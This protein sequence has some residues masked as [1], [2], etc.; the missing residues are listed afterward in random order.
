MYREAL[1]KL[2]ARRDLEPEE[3]EAVIAEL[4]DGA[5]TPEEMSALLVA[6]TAKGETAAELAGFA[7]AMRAR[8]VKVDAG[9]GLLDTCGTGGSGLTTHNTS[10]M[11]AFVTAAAGGRIAKHGNRASTGKCGSMDVL[12][13]LDVPID[14]GPDAVATLIR[15]LGVGFMLAPRHH[16]AM[17]HVAPVRKALGVR[18]TFNFV[19]PLSNPAGA[20][21]QLLG[22]SDR[23]RARPMA[24]AL[25]AL[26]TV[27]AMIVNGDDGL[28]EITL[29]GSTLVQRVEGGRVTEERIEP[30]A[31][32]LRPVPFAAIEGGDPDDNARAVID[33]L[34]GRRTG[35]VRDHVALNA[36]AALVVLGLA[37]DLASGLARAFAILA[38]GAAL[39]RLRRYRDRAKELA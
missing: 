9:P 5:L 26:G 18:T 4:M 25:L 22:V 24:E 20:D 7:R 8:A 2:E 30:G 31:L 36:A 3:A 14:L 10:T 17:R 27:R 39:E 32:G 1:E 33:V 21:H 34:G 6:I 11:V 13:A 23:R 12:E 16:P 28:D 35:A 15:E 38:S 19:G 37:E 29:T